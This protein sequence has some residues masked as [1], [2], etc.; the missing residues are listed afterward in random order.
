QEMIEISYVDTLW[1]LIAS[2]LVFIMHLGFATLE[3]GF[4]RSK[5]TIS[6]IMKNL[7]TVIV[8]S[9]VFFIIGFSIAF[10]GD[11]ALIGGV[12]FAFMNGITSAPWGDLALPSNVFFLFQMMFAA[13]AATIVSGAVAERI[14]FTSYLVICALLVAFIY[15][16]IA[17]WIWGG[18]WLA[19]RGFLDFAGSTVVH[20][21]GG[22][23]ALASAFVL[24]PRIGKFSHD[25]KPL[26]IAGHDIGLATIGLFLL[27]V[28]WFGFNAGSELAVNEMLGTIATTTYLSAVGGGF[29]ALLLTWKRNGKPDT[30]MTMN[31]ILAGLV[32]ITAPCAFVTPLWAVLIGLV[33]GVIV[34]YAVDI[35]ESRFKIDDPVGAISV[36][37]INGLWG[38]LAVGLFASESGL[39]TTGSVSQLA[40]Q[41]LGAGATFLLVFPLSLL[42]AYGIDKSMGLRVSETIELRGLDTTEFGGD[43]YPEFVRE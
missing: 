30:S 17:H 36:H 34:V 35:I 39:L 22:W 1:V 33:A 7:S 24:G 2:S 20:S 8:G 43:A 10:S 15:P 40:T 38:T 3:A 9:L 27:W 31:G 26:A 32:A 41:A 37:G 21:V 6:I 5:N 19:E 14:K 28:G 25:G 29:S 42:I 18:G 16:T 12:N 11:G 4:T 13:T 23:A